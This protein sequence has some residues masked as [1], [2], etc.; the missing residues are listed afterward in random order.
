M[1]DSASASAKRSLSSALV[2]EAAGPVTAPQPVPD[3]D[4]L[5]APAARAG[6]HRVRPPGHGAPTDSSARLADELCHGRHV[7]W[8][9]RPSF[10]S[11]V[12]LARPQSRGLQLRAIS[13]SPYVPGQPAY[14]APAS[15]KRGPAQSAFGNL[16]RRAL[17]V[18]H[19]HPRVEPEAP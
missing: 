4:D 9:T 15:A 3:A 16:A 10:E 13:E 5:A 8:A 6:G 2:I 18:L 12:Q 7:K 17:E 11:T 14:R 1:D 19:R